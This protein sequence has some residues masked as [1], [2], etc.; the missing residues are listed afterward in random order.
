MDVQNKENKTD[1]NSAGAHTTMEQ[2]AEILEKA[3]AA[4][5]NAYDKT[6]EAAG[7]AYKKTSEAMGNAYDKTSEAVGNAYDKTAEAAGNAYD[8]TS[9]VV[10]NAYDKTS[11]AVSTTYG[12]VVNYGSENPGKTILIALGLGAGV[13]FMI[14]AGYR[15]SRNSRFAQ[16]VV[17]ALSDIAMGFFR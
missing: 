17:N 11:K 3:E 2:G 5:S 9:E 15:S 6:A 4:A 13:G 12:V 8:K 14:G 1:K 10:G 16:P 7:N